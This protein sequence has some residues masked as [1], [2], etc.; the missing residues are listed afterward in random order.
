MFIS[1]TENAHLATN[2]SQVLSL[3]KISCEFETNEKTFAK[4]PVRDKY[5]M[6]LILLCPIPKLAKKVIQRKTYIHLR[7]ADE[8]HIYVSPFLRACHA[9]QAEYAVAGNQLPKRKIGACLLLQDKNHLIDEWIAYHRLLGVERVYIY[10]NEFNES[11]LV[12][13]KK[14]FEEDFVVPIMWP[15]VS[16]NKL[17]YSRMQY[18]QINDCLWRFRYLH[19]WLLFSD[20]DE[21]I[22][23]LPGLDGNSLKEFLESLESRADI[24]G[25][26]AHNV[27]FGLDSKLSYEPSLLVTEQAMCRQERISKDRPKTIAR[28]QNVYYMW[29]H[30]PSIGEK[31]LDAD[32]YQELRLV[33]YKGV[34][35]KPPK[36]YPPLTIFDNSMKNIVP[37]IKE[38]LRKQPRVYQSEFKMTQ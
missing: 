9:T 15:F 17:P 27:F 28:P 1:S 23:P 10:F 33:H 34:D 25:V 35:S 38:Q 31:C 24:G 16:P 30:K 29:N 3:G 6:V 14:Y 7:Y 2:Y 19:D 8:E 20:V 22:Q 5:D 18:V 4:F 12:Q 37:L 21:Y 36:W 32:P 26:C 11:S 13:F